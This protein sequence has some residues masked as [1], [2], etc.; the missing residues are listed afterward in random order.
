MVWHAERFVYNRRRMSQVRNG[1]RESSR[2][3][4]THDEDKPA[5]WLPE[6]EEKSSNLPNFIATCTGKHQR[7]SA[8]MTKNIQYSKNLSSCKC[9]QRNTCF[10]TTSSDTS[11]N[12]WAKDA[13]LEDNGTLSCGFSLHHVLPPV[14]ETMTGP[15]VQLCF[16]IWDRS[17]HLCDCPGPCGTL[18]HVN[19]YVW[20][21]LKPTSPTNHRYGHQQSQQML[22]CI[23][24]TLSL[25]SFNKTA[26][27]KGEYVLVYLLWV[28]LNH[29]LS[30]IHLRGFFIF[31]RFLLTI[32]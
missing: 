12:R 32:S 8:I 29:F 31:S 16:M 25:D 10:L 23:T 3:I 13:F 27:S 19:L 24:Q 1:D 5:S 22:D 26:I 4:L 2:W 15:R 9:N 21:Q 28:R 11:G 18:E 30:Y 14:F 7:H 17:I 20:Q 6:L